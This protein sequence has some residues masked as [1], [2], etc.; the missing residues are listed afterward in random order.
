MK[1]TTS[2]L[3]KIINTICE[4]LVSIGIKEIEID[5]DYYWDIDKEVLYDPSQKPNTLELGQL[6]Y[7]VEILKNVLNGKH[8]PIGW[9]F[10]P[11]SAVLRYAG[12][13]YM[14]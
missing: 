12:E 10:V 7:D 8:A 14:S 1:I 9:H 4:H 5:Q 2:E 3:E 11:L 6:S 13:K